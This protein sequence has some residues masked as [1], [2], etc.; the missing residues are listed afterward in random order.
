MRLFSLGGTELRIHWGM[1]PMLLLYAILGRFA[2]LAA[3]L[4]VLILH[5]TAHA[6][7]AKRLRVRVYALTLYPFGA[8]ARMDES[9]MLPAEEGLIA[10]AGPVLNLVLCGLLLIAVR[11]FPAGEGILL[12]VYR[13]S[14]AL[15]LINLLPAYPLDGGRVLRSVLALRLRI[16]TAG[17]VAAW[18]SIAVACLLLAGTLYAF[19]LHLDVLWLAVIGVF[20]LLAAARAVLHL[21]EAQ[22]G[23]VMRRADAV[24]HGHALRVEVTALHASVPAVDAVRE[25]QGREYGL[26]RV[27]DDA[28]HQV[29]ELDEGMLISGIAKLGTEATVGEI[30]RA[31]DRRLIV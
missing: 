28:M 11:L 24:R 18:L 5:E 16:R 6:L 3:S 17:A 20:L 30:L 23:G 9:S 25:L 19:L 13:A 7:T 29:G 31:F 22:L 15:A 21:P 4:G 1:W 8:E 27:V 14:M 10:C 2:Q 12:P 26:L